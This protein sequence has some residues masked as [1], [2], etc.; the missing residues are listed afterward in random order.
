MKYYTAIDDNYVWP[1]LVMLFSGKKNSEFSTLKFVC[2]FDSKHLS[3]QS[4]D[5]ILSVADVL[6]TEIEFE[7]LSLPV[8][9]ATV[10]HFTPTVFARL[11]LADSLN[12]PFIWVDA[13]TLLLNGFQGLEAFAKSLSGCVAAVPEKASEISSV[14]KARLIKGADYFNSGVMIINPETWRLHGHSETW[15]DAQKHSVEL[16]FEWPDQCVLNYIVENDYW[17]LPS[18][19]NKFWG[20][21]LDR[22][23]NVLHFI[24]ALKPWHLNSGLRLYRGQSSQAFLDFLLYRSYEDALMDAVVQSPRIYS[25]LMEIRMAHKID[26]RK[27]EKRISATLRLNRYIEKFRMKF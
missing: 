13:D 26:E 17:Q 14:N 19:F 16:G 27:S 18:S 11:I 15:P 8:E 20:K 24:G 4:R 9:I 7:E 22:D 1:Y 23:P 25:K 2:A 21:G 10:G 6:N 3:T 5:L 12:S